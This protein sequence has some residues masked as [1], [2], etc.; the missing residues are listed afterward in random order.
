MSDDEYIYSDDEYNNYD[1]NDDDDEQ[2]L[3][4]SIEKVNIENTSKSIENT[5]KEKK[6]NIEKTIDKISK[7]Y[8]TLWMKFVELGYIENIDENDDILSIKLTNDDKIYI[9]VNL[10][11]LFKCEIYELHNRFIYHPILDLS[12]NLRELNIN[13]KKPFEVLNV[14]IDTKNFGIGIDFIK[15]LLYNVPVDLPEVTYELTLIDELKTFYN[16]INK[17]CI[18]CYKDLNIIYLKPHSCNN[19]LCKYYIENNNEMLE[20]EINHSFNKLNF[21]YNLYKDAVLQTYSVN[22]IDSENFIFHYSDN[23]INNINKIISDSLISNISS[24]VSL[25]DELIENIQQNPSPVIQT[26]PSSNM[27]SVE[28]RIT[29]NKRLEFIKEYIKEID[30]ITLDNY[31]DRVLNTILKWIVSSNESQIHELLENEK[32]PEFKE[33]NQYLILSSNMDKESYFQ[34]LKK[35]YPTFF[36]FHGSG[37]KNWF[38]ILQSGLKVLSGTN[39]MTSGAIYGS[40]IYTAFD[41]YIS[42]K[43]SRSY[44]SKRIYLAICEIID[45]SKFYKKVLVD[46]IYNYIIVFNDKMIIPRIILEVSNDNIKYI[47]DKHISNIN[48]SSF[49]KTN[50]VDN[51]F[52][53]IKE[54]IKDRC[55]ICLCDFDEED[56]P[57]KGKKC[58]DGHY[59]HETCFNHMIN[60]SGNCCICN[61][62]YIPKYGSQPS[63]IMSV[64][65]QHSKLNGYPESNGTYHITFNMPGNSDLGYQGR[66]VVAYLPVTSKG[67]IVLY[68]LKKAFDN[69]ILFRLDT[70][71]TTGVYGIVFSSIHLKTSQIGPYGYPDEGYLDRTI[72]AL[73]AN[74]I[75]YSF[76]S[77]KIK[78]MKKTRSK[79]TGSKKKNY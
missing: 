78:K 7:R 13:N 57:V 23:F 68:M 65:I 69:N 40:G 47:N 77:R 34:H 56:K 64:D 50:I 22:N 16:L 44:E 52:I 11:K 6:V 37:N 62:Y 41:S 66:T 24:D 2:I 46:N 1:Y 10:L 43:Y 21:L 67:K 53:T 38:S 70:S 19:T 4:E 42:L 26:V 3:A 12:I 74:G 32:I 5:S 51:Y 17:K 54:Q 27:A 14:S 72:E 61:T 35:Q 49:I 73:I 58:K 79:K 75:T 31:K 29:P 76:G 15:N 33:A 36:A 71:N 45:D 9:N 55:S 60:T 25:S 39:K 30:I 59:Y 8:Y 28:M 48:I 18:Y 20:F 63:G